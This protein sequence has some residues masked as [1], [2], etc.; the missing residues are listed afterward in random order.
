MLSVM[1]TA[2]ETQPS[3]QFLKAAPLAKRLSVTPKTIHRWHAA[4]YFSARK[5]SQRV[6]LFDL[7]EVMAFIE[8]A[9]VGS[10]QVA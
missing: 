3:S 2:Q 7:A 9:R 10:R 6:V 4:G 5:V 8:A 1:K